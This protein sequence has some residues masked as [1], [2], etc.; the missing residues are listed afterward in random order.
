MKPRF[1]IL[2]ALLLTAAAG[3]HGQQATER[4]IPIGQSPGVSGKSTMIGT[5]SALDAGTRTLSVQSAAGAQ[6]VKLSDQT[7]LWLD[8]S[9]AQQSTQTATVA[10]LR[11]GRRVEVKFADESARTTAE[12]IKVEAGTPP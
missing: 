1:R 11:A 3:A 9:A 12:W 10:D 7:R 4:F 5:V 6:R 8:R 2:F